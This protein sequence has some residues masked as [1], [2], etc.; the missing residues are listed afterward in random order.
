M[1][2]V[3]QTAFEWFVTVLTGGVA[4]AWLVYDAFNLYKTRNADR[5]DPIVRD[6]H[7]GYVVGMVIGI[8]GVLGCLRFHGVV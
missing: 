5:Q 6:K 4:G 1:N 2:I 7:F 8:V 3:S